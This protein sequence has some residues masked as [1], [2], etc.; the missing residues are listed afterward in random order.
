MTEQER[1]VSWGEAVRSYL[2]PEVVRMLFLGF[3]AGL[4]L[5]LIFGTLSVWLNEAGIDKSTVTFFS[6]AALSYSFKFIWAPLV[7]K[8]PLPWLTRSLGRRRAWLL[9]SQMGIIA[10]ILFMSSVNPISEGSIQLTLVALGAVMLGFSSATQDIAIDAYR[11]ESGSVALQPMMSAMYMGG[12]RLGMIVA[13]AGALYLASHWGSTLSDYIYQA[14]SNTY[15]VMASF[16]LIGLVTTLV[17]KEPES[18]CEGNA[19][20]NFDYIRF[21]CLFLCAVI[22]F[23]WFFIKSAEIAGHAIT[24]L[25]LVVKNNVLASVVVEAVRLLLA[26]FSAITTAL[27]LLKIRFANRKMVKEAYVEPVAD[28][29][30]RYSFRAVIILLL[31][32]GF[33]RISD[34]VLGVI[35]NIFYQDVG[36]SK[37]E[38]ASASKAF[39]LGMIIVGGFLGGALALRI[40]VMRLMFLGAL[41]AS[42]TNLLFM[43]LAGSDHNLWLLYLVVAADN[44]SGGIALSAFIA[45]LSGLT[46]ISFTAMQYAIFSSLMTLFPKII[47]GYSGAIVEAMGY[48]KFFLVTALMGVPVL[49]L[50]FLASRHLSSNDRISENPL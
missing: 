48:P 38:I 2:K 37:N 22:V 20:N 14:W 17:I 33:Y 26:G 47:G 35:A 44:L 49:V 6:W 24:E 27:F 12:Y 10:A 16:A 34:I 3:S 45:F 29:F 40:G 1:T 9:L 36:Y 39:G 42:A 50:V 31:L 21:F 15:K 4:P 32:I 46:S 11:I 41:L 43:L 30:N 7:D 19:Y 23:I 13:G 28:F 25:S 8:L 18:K 5:A